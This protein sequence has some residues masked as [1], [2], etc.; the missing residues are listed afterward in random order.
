VI[1]D[2]AASA[3]DGLILRGVK[4]SQLFGKDLLNMTSEQFL[5]IAA[6]TTFDERLIDGEVTTA[7]VFDKKCGVGDVIEE[8]LDDGQFRGDA[9]RHFRECTGK[10]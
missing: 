3:D 9:R 6:A 7:S 1:D 10:C 2:C 8:L 5:L 4:P